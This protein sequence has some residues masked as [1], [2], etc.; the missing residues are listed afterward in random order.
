VVEEADAE[1]AIS[2]EAAAEAAADVEEGAADEFAGGV[3]AKPNDCDS[4]TAETQPPNRGAI[5]AQTAIAAPCGRRRDRAFIEIRPAKRSPTLSAPHTGACKDD[6]HVERIALLLILP[7]LPVPVRCHWQASARLRFVHH[8]G[9]DEAPRRIGYQEPVFSIDVQGSE[10]AFASPR[11][12]ISI[13]MLSGD[14]TKAMRPSRGG[15]LMVTPLSM[16]DRH[17]S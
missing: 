8:C 9:T 17:V 11:C 13:E 4:S 7:N 1:D 16:S 10:G 12:R 15:R 14:F 5:T 3:G 6:L 2:T